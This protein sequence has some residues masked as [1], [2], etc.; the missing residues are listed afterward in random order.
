MK[1][2]LL[3]I[4][5]VASL[6][7]VIIVLTKITPKATVADIGTQRL[8]RWYANRDHEKEIAPERWQW[9][10]DHGIDPNKDFDW[11]QSCIDHTLHPV[12]GE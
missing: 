2:I 9:F 7:A 6:F 12:A 3:G 1:K 4:I 5:G 11:Y 10:K 8:C